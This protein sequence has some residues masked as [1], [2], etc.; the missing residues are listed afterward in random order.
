MTYGARSQVAWNTTNVPTTP[1]PEGYQIAPYVNGGFPASAASNPYGIM[2][3]TSGTITY[4]IDGVEVAKSD[5]GA[6]TSGLQFPSAVYLSTAGL[7][8]GIHTIT[9]EYSGDPVSS[10]SSYSQ[11]FTVAPPAPGTPFVCETTYTGIPTVN[12]SVVAVATVPSLA[13]SGSSV[14]VSALDLTLNIDPNDGLYVGLPV[15]NVTIGFSPGGVTITPPA[16]T[17]TE[18]NGINSVSWTG[19]STT[20]PISGTPGSVVPVGVSSLSFAGSDISYACNPTD[21]TAPAVVQQVDVSGTTLTTSPSN[22]AAVGAPVT[23]T[24]TVNPTPS[25]WQDDPIVGQVDFFD[26]TT[27]LGT[28][29]V[30]SVGNPNAGIATLT[31]TS[32]A[33]GAH[34]LTAVWSGGPTPAQTSP[35]V[36]FQVG[37]APTVTTQPTNQTTS[38][39]ATATFTAAA[40][41]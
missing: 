21:P 7:T 41:R 25:D 13:P 19:L 37:T 14:P 23:L 9:F 31:T 28:V 40:N 39:G 4:L 2:P 12:A 20:V 18:A 36:N 26:G 16:A 10:P 27:D 6:G 24:A 17:P 38:A 22:S 11:T 1:V 8:P 29:G 35:P 15:N 30:P 33:P 34:T 5:A 32:L 3:Y